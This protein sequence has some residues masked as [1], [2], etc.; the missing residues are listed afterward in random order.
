MH[1]TNTN[2]HKS[3][4]GSCML[5]EEV[6]SCTRGTLYVVCGG[7]CMLYKKDV[8]CCVR[9]VVCCVWGMLYVVQVYVVSCI[10]YKG[11]LYVV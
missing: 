10:L 4:E 11:T 1:I 3:S 5:L 6:V 7:C 2:T 9:G 8:V